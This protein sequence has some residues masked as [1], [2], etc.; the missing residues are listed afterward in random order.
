[1]TR[2]IK[3]ILL[4]LFGIK[5]FTSDSIPKVIIVKPDE[6]QLTLTSYSKEYFDIY[7]T[8]GYSRF[9]LLK[10]RNYLGF[11][12]GLGYLAHKNNLLD[13]FG[14]NGE[15]VYSYMTRVQYVHKYT[16]RALYFALEYTY[17]TPNQGYDYYNNERLYMAKIGLKNYFLKN[18]LSITPQIG[19]G[20][21]ESQGIYYSQYGDGR[22]HLNLGFDIGFCF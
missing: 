2:T 18:Y 21:S 12:A 11:Y 22:W 10:N 16:K 3:I 8:I 15:G 14:F 7:H 9:F 1:M 6:I 20:I 19:I 4:L 17:L 5:G 13:K